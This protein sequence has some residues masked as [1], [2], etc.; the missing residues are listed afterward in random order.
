MEE[1]LYS[2]KLMIS[3]AVK[4]METVKRN[5]TCSQ[6]HMSVASILFESMFLETLIISLIISK[7][8]MFSNSM[9]ILEMPI[10]KI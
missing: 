1:V 8:N 10:R 3:K 7:S 9:K 2:E 6:R 5:K 4:K